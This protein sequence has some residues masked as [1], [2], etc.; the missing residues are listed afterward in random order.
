METEGML[1]V[2]KDMLWNKSM[3]YL[4]VVI[5]F[6]YLLT[7]PAVKGKIGE[8]FVNRK[9]RK[10]NPQKYVLLN[11]V[12]LTSHNGKTAQI[13]HVL[14]SI[15]G[16]FVIETKNYRGWIFG[17]ENRHMWTQTIY[18]KKSKFLNPIIQN[19]GH[20]KALQHLLGEKYPALPF[21]PIVS[22]S[23]RADFKKMDVQSHVVYSVQL[24]KVIQQYQEPVLTEQEMR[25]IVNK[26]H[27]ADIKGAKA[28]KEHVR[29]IK[30]DLAANRTMPQ[31][32]RAGKAA[33]V[34]EKTAGE[35]THGS[36][37]SCRNPLVVRKGKRGIFLGCSRF[38]A[39]RYTAEFPEAVIPAATERP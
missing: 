16:I 28:R 33:P 7:L 18:K 29:D 10:L 31:K 15:Y 8:S 32:E 17:S 3:I 24:L 26:I 22:F 13:D 25:D 12:L 5:F 23:S 20:I 19:K 37:P 14:I 39:C 6:L 1:K 21:I 38:P 35:T 11:D 2:I 9:L 4:Y 27:A 36:C 30:A 34:Q